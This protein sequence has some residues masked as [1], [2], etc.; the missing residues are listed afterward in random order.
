MDKMDLG[1]EPE[2]QISKKLK[3]R[4]KGDECRGVVMGQYL[5]SHTSDVQVIFSLAFR[6]QRNFEN[7]TLL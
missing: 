2:K 1:S 7:G 4:G 3:A 5:D 6:F